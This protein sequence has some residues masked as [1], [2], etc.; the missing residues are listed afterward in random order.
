MFTS[1]S[2]FPQP[3]D[4]VKKLLEDQLGRIESMSAEAAKLEERAQSDAKTFVEEWSRLASASFGYA[5]QLS[6]EW[7]KLSMEATKK[8]FEAMTPRS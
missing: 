3:T 2:A 4:T 1:F 5:A 7:R 6:A 8:T